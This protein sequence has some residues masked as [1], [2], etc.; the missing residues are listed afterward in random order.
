[1]IGIYK[2]TNKQNGKSYIGQAT[3]IERRIAEHKQTRT[4][5]IDNYIN[6]LGVDNFDF[7]IIEECPLED[8][9]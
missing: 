6:V 1:M 8:F 3:N 7:E 4:Q 5:T 9:D 2:I